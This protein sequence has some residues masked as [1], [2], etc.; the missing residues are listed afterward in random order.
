M[1]CWGIFFRSFVLGSSFACMATKHNYQLTIKFLKAGAGDS[2]LIRFVGTDNAPRHILI[3]GGAAMAYPQNLCKEVEELVDR[4]EKL[5]LVIVTH[6]DDDHAK[7][8]ERLF[9]DISSGKFPA[10]LIGESWINALVD[11]EPDSALISTRTAK[12]IIDDLIAAKNDQRGFKILVR[13]E[14]QIGDAK[15]QILTPT[16]AARDRWEPIFIKELGSKAEISSSREDCDH[17]LPL[18]SLKDVV[19][20]K[21]SSIKNSVS[22]AFILTIGSFKGLFL[23]DAWA[24][25]IEA[26]LIHLGYSE[27]N[28]LHVDVFKL[29]HHGGFGN[30]STELLNLVKAKR[31][32]VTSIGGDKCKPSKRTIAKIIHSKHYASTVQFLFNYPEEK[33]QNLLT[34]EESNQLNLL[35]SNYAGGHYLEQSP[36]K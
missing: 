17:R 29:S 16:Q 21:D 2:I 20:E 31:Y 27:D 22:I 18:D 15:L 19:Q 25:D 30:I 34:K 9:K 13:E 35:F 10:D 7:G 5:D 11:T 8:I 33:Y 12:S 32:V 6:H 1:R 3:D 36:T 26:Q 23:G 24:D 14:Y 4:G 28:P